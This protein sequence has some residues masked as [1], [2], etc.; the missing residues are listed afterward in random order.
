MKNLIDLHFGTEKIYYG[1]IFG[2]YLKSNLPQGTTTLFIGNADGENK[3]KRKWHRY[4]VCNIFCKGCDCLMVIPNADELARKNKGFTCPSCGTFH[5]LDNICIAENENSL[6]PCFMNIR[7][8]EKKEAVEL[9]IRYNAEMMGKNVYND[10][11]RVDKVKEIFTFDTK[12]HTVVWRRY[13]D[14]HLEEVADIGYIADLKNF[15]EKSALYWLNTTYKDKN[16][17]TFCELLKV[18]RDKINERMKANGLSKRNM[19]V[20]GSNQYKAVDN[21]LYIAHQVRFWD[22]KDTNAYGNGLEKFNEWKYKHKVDIEIERKTEL[23]MKEG[24]QYIEA[25]VKACGLPNTKFVRKNISLET[26]TLLKYAHCTTRGAVKY[27]YDTFCR[28]I[29]EA[30]KKKKSYRFEDLS[31]PAYAM[32]EQTCKF[33]ETFEKHYPQVP[34]EKMVKVAESNDGRDTINLWSVTDEDSRNIFKENLP[35]FKEL[36]DCLSLLVAQQKDR[37]LDFK[38]PE[39]IIRRMDMYLK[40]TNCKVLEKFSQVKKASLELKNCASGYRNRINENLQL[41]LMS[42]DNGKPVV[43]MEINNGKIIQ[44]K[45]FANVSVKNNQE[46]NQAV[47]EFAKKAQL[48]IRTDD[49]QVQDTETQITKVA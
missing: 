33:I 2:K 14:D 44:A 18:L 34:I 22:S 19:Y 30:E 11:M 1:I 21:V 12:K 3:L 47:I 29:D 5:K 36:H 32:I 49:V 15:V 38:I 10:Y 9:I 27:L 40:N 13:I 35:K 17:K 25:L 37:E 42:D 28:W 8:T 41:V 24:N 4:G 23:L 26:A 48:I 6:L 7:L 20:N 39:H 46:L 31:R 16:G 43:L 45:L